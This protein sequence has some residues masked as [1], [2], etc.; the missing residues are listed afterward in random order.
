MTCCGFRYAFDHRKT[1]LPETFSPLPGVSSASK[2]GWPLTPVGERPR[3]GGA[4]RPGGSGY[5]SQDPKPSNDP[6][7]L[8]DGGVVSAPTASECKAPAA[9]AV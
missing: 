6:R 1:G 5:R 4:V 2:R 3:F 7:G 8:V 9:M